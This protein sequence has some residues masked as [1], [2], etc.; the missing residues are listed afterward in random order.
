VVAL[1]LLGVDAASAWLA[2]GHRQVAVDAVAGVSPELPAFFRNGGAVVGHAAIDPDLWRNRDTP[3]LADR[4][5]PEHYLDLELLRGAELPA[6][7]DDYL[8]LLDR[9]RVSPRKAGALPYAI[10]EGSERLALC[11]AEHRRWPADETIRAKC[12]LQAG[13]LAHYL[14]DL[15]Q[16][17]H[18]TIHHDGRVRGG[19]ESP[20]SGIHR[21]VDALLDAAGDGGRVA[22][23]AVGDL[24]AAIRSELR[25]SHGLVDE[26]YRLEPKLDGDRRRRDPR[27]AAFADERR[28]AAVRLTAGVFEWCWRRSVAI[29]LPEWLRR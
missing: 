27:V 29:E 5:A 24:G 25:A 2:T 20:R 28:R 19:G 22:P 15:T 13:W 14:A 21:R 9:L 8:R 23:L 16:P 10:V 17:L 11:F 7:R 3:A 6:E 18:T 26:V 12:L 1:S 4:E